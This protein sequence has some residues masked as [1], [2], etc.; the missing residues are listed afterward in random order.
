MNDIIFVIPFAGGSSRSFHGWH[1]QENYEFVFIDMP[2]KGN[3]EGEKLLNH[4]GEMVE[5]GYA[6]ITHYLEVHPTDRYFI[7]GHSMGSYLAFEIVRQMEQTRQKTP[8]CL[9]MSGTMP[10]ECFT[11]YALK[12]YMA[13]DDK[14]L[15]YIVSFGLVS[16]KIAGSRIFRTKFLPAVKKDYEALLEYRKCSGILLEQ[17]A[18]IMNGKDDEFTEEMVHKWKTYFEISPEFLWFEGGHFFILQNAE[19]LLSTLMDFFAKSERKNRKMREKLI[20]IVAEVLKLSEEDKNRIDG[21]YDLTTIGL[22]SLNA[23]EVVVNLEAEFD[24]MVDDDDLSLD[25]LATIEMLEQIVE[26]Y[27]EE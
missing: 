14:F 16:A 20:E 4:F 5:E 12:E 24:I 27:S 17:P 6:Q 1:T 26:K 25:N 13:D 9:I 21:D 10:P 11:G 3:R 19:T 22:D 23:I 7:W 15:Q 8:A 2:G 18:I